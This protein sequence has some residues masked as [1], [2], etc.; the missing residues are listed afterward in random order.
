MTP[1]TPDLS[2]EKEIAEQADGIKRSLAMWF[3][4]NPHVKGHRRIAIKPYK[5]V[6]GDGDMDVNYSITQSKKRKVE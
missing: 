1:E 4:E 6:D 2:E 3:G 5:D